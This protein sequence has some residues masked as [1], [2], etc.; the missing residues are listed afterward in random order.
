M[1]V[2][3]VGGREFNDYDLVKITMH[4]LYPDATVIVSGGARGA[5][6]LGKQYADDHGLIAEIYDADWPTLTPGCRVGINRSGKQY[7]KDAGHIR[8]TTIV[9]NSDAIVAFWDGNSPGTRDTVKKIRATGK[10]LHVINY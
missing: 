3:I 2:G 1:K 7:N 6:S 5:D 8:N 9:E 10:P 4:R